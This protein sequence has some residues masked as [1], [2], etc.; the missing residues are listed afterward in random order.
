M[1][2]LLTKLGSINKFNKLGYEVGIGSMYGAMD[3]K[4]A[5]GSGSY[6]QNNIEYCKLLKETISELGIKKVIDFGC[7]NLET[8]TNNI[9]WENE[10]TEY[11]GYEINKYCLEYL[12]ET[13]PQMTF[14]QAHLK[15]MPTDKAD[16]IIIK[17]VFIHWFDEDIKWFIQEAMKQYRYIITSNETTD[18]GYESKHGSR[19]HAPGPW[20]VYGD[21]WKDNIQNKHLYGFKVLPYNILPANK[22]IKSQ[23][24]TSNNIKTFIVIDSEK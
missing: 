1:S 14:K 22:I 11:L 3:I 8:Y 19:R 23:N 16:A 15:T 20:K 9:N 17:D 10:E 18:Q 7:G 24:W 12:Y 4:K 13:Y 5:S 6:P 2:D 21:Q